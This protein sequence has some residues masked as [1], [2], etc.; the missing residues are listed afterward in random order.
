MACV[1]NNRL[2]VQKAGEKISRIYE[3]TNKTYHTNIYLHRI[4]YS[5]FTHDFSNL[6]LKFMIFYV[7]NHSKNML[8]DKS[9]CS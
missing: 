2:L 8:Q 1:L 6:I 9:K 3:V 7:N 5:N 4:I